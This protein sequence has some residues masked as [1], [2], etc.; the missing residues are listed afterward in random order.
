MPENAGALGSGETLPSCF[1]SHERGLAVKPH[2][3]GILTLLLLGVSL[4]VCEGL[5]R[6]LPGTPW[7]HPGKPG[8]DPLLTRHPERGYALKPDQDRRW[9]RADF[10]V[11]VRTNGRGMRD[12]SFAAARGS[13]LRILAAGDSFTFG[14]GV[15]AEETWP[16]VLERRLEADRGGN[17]RS[18]AVLDLGVPGYSARQIRRW[19][20][21]VW[22]QLE[23][24]MVVVGL[25]MPSYW[26]VRNPYVLKGGTLIHTAGLERVEVRPDGSRMLVDLPPGPLRQLEIWLKERSHLAGYV[27]TAP[28]ALWRRYRSVSRQ[29]DEDAIRRAWQPVTRELEALHGFATARGGRLVVLAINKQERDGSFSELQS[30]YNGILA[31]FCREAGVTCVDPLPRMRDEAGGRP[32]FRFPEDLHWPPRA[33]RLAGEMVYEVVARELRARTP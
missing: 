7:L 6:M 33:H 29:V 17:P 18:V 24:R 26:R 32:V 14:I 19:V 30:L 27:L 8:E 22:P 12:E 4:V 10:D 15:E 2:T 31:S 9:R 21:E 1:S 20:E 3:T 23:P 16:E 11:A 28:R 25:Y 13:E 5:A